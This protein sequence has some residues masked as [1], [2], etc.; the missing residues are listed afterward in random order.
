MSKHAARQANNPSDYAQRACQPCDRGAGN[1]CWQTSIRPIAQS[2]PD[3]WQL[4]CAFHRLKTT[5]SLV[6]RSVWRP[7]SQPNCG[8]RFSYYG[9]RAILVLY[10]VAPTEDG[11]LGMSTAQAVSIYGVYSAMVWLLAVPGGW[12][13]DRAGSSQDCAHWRDRYRRWPLRARRPDILGNLARAACVAIGTG[14]LKPNI[15]AMVG[16]LYD[17][18]PDEGERRDAYFDLLHGHQHRWIYRA[19]RLWLPR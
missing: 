2:S 10:L 12:L 6:S 16:G 18:D 4:S 13:S 19:V 3:S 7:C 5:D 11:G 8:E 17:E 9:M 15:S 14:M 1:D